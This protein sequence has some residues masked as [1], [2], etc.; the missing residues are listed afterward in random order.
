MVITATSKSIGIG[1]ATLA[2][3][4]GV[5]SGTATAGPA[6]SARTATAHAGAADA[7][8]AAAKKC[9]HTTSLGWYCGY[10]KGHKTVK[11][12]SSGQAVKEVQANI[13]QTTDYKPKL[14]VDGE[15]GSKTKKAVLWFQHEF[16]IK[17]YDAIVGPKTWKVLRAK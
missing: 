10:Y 6:D 12:G 3:L 17:P 8:T 7:T 2:L 15:F 9:K 14:K 13:N 4:G 16:K 5:A 11:F 1:I